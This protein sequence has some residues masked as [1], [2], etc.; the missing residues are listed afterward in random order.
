MTL[1]A[2]ACQPGAN[3]GTLALS[4]VIEATQ[5]TVVAQVGGRVVEI[6]ADEGDSV[7]AG[8]ALVR[9]DDAALQ[10]EVKQALA[11]VS[12]AEASL[13]QVMSGAR[14]EDIA[15]AQAQLAQTQAERDG[16]ALAYRDAGKILNN[17]QQ[18][19]AQTDAARTAVTLTE[20]SVAVAQSKL[21]EARWWRD[22][23]DGEPGRRASLNKQIATAQ[24]NLEAA[25][26]LLDGAKAQVKA[27]EAMRYAPVTLRAQVNSAR[28]SYS[29]TL[30]SVSVAE[31]ALAELKAGSS[32]EEIALAKAQLHQAQVQLELAQAYQSRAVVRAPLTGVI[33]SRSTRVGEIAQ[34]GAALLSVVNLD[35]V[36]LV[37]YVPQTE[38]P[39]VQ[40]GAAV[41]VSVDAYPGQV[42]TGQVTS[43]ARQ[44][45]FTPRD[46]QAREDRTN[47]VFAV[48]VRL[49]NA[50]HRLKAGMTGD[51]VIA[52]QT[53]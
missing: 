11:A 30:A 51:A 40:P 22:F 24:Y 10:V 32:P 43:I 52:A 35:K 15:V 7:Q 27:L 8:Q 49:P 26:A 34:P 13:A 3:S 2:T 39:R 21:A 44:A 37:V 50:D 46:I 42:F 5:A 28:S 36:T 33:V 18:L 20:Q 23:Y 45:E 47:V 17:P 14:K 19:L 48:K 6:A 29:M 53:R 41:Q 4:G 38:L 31:A 16:A 9:L 1:A 25:Q 12:A